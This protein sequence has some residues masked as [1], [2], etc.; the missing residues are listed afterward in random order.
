M[1]PLEQK[2]QGGG[3]GGAWGMDIFWNHSIYICRVAKICLIGNNFTCNLTRA[4]FIPWIF[5]DF[6]M[7]QISLKKFK[8]FVNEK[9]SQTV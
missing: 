4:I 9:Y 8:L 1:T 6:K 2:F 7:D 3:G 5:A